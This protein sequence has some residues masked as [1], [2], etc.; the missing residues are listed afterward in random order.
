VP[1]PAS[2]WLLLSG[3]LLLG[4]ALRDGRRVPLAAAIR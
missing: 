2:A 3:L 4:W 1:L